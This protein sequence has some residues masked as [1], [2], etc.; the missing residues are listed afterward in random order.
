M[1]TSQGTAPATNPFLLVNAQ[2]TDQIR[3]SDAVELHGLRITGA[4]R[5]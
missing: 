1:R 3:S 4:I 5:F 2:G